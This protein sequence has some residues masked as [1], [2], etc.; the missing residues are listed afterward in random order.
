M[1]GTAGTNRRWCMHGETSEPVGPFLTAGTCGEY[2]A[3]RPSARRFRQSGWVKF[4]DHLRTWDAAGLAALL[5]ARPD[6]LPAAD[7]GFEALARRASTANSL[8]R[9][10][11][12]S[13]VAMF[14][15]AQ[16]LAVSHPA[17]A[18]EIDDLLGTND[19]DAVLDALGRLSAQGIVVV[20]D[21]VASPVGALD[22]LFH[23][24]LGLGPSF[25]ELADHL[26][27]AVFDDLAD[28]LGAAGATKRSATSRAIA[29]RLRSPE[30]LR[31]AFEGAP[32]EAGEL[33][34]VLVEQRSPAV[35]LPVG[36]R[37]Q[38]PPDDEPLA[39]MLNHGLLAPVSES[40]AELPR[41]IVIGYRSDGLTPQAMLRP[42]EPRPVAGL[43]VESVIAAAADRAG[44]TLEAAESLLRLVTDGEVAVRKTGGVGIREL[45]RLAKLL[46]LEDRQVGRLLELLAEAKLLQAQRGRLVSTPLADA[47][48]NLARGRRWLI[49]V[50]AWLA[51]PGFLSSA[52]SVGADDRPV[53]ALI[54]H[55]TV[56]AAFAGR[57][58][59][60]E[61]I[62]AI[63]A[64]EAFDPDQLCTAVVWRSPNLWGAGEPPPEDL[65]E[66][67]FAEAELLGLTAMNAPSPTLTA[68]ASDDTDRLEASAAELLGNDQQQFVL[69]SDLTAVALGPLDPGVAGRLNDLADRESDSSVPQYRFSESSLRRG[70][71]RGWSAET[72]TAFLSDHALSG[73]PQPLAY[74]LADVDRRY[75]SVKVVAASAVIVTEDEALAVEVASTTR[76]ARLGLRLIAPTV[77]VGPVDP[78]ELV[79]EL[80]AEGFFPIFD[81]DTI[82]FE[83]DIDRGIDDVGLP[84]DWTGPGLTEAALAGEVADAVE[85]LQATD[86]GISAEPDAKHRLHLLWNRTAVVTHLR[87]GRLTEARGVVVAV[88]ESLTL[89]NENGVEELPM[90]AVVTVEDPS[91]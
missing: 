66:W 71:D 10:L 89:L 65:V 44:R 15:V 62:S 38:R 6:L 29:R 56:A 78:H 57:Q 73:L 12:R 67:T 5:S 20:E 14:L 13:D 31:R 49:L 63:P 39:W 47:W 87:D 43:P 64:G 23:R 58:V 60:I 50:R 42:I 25:V 27:P 88:D 74:L 69:Q 34:G 37:Y 52:L 8:G 35:G 80:R 22:D 46:E 11:V 81:G 76:A 40:V 83:A 4:A 70:L 82:R 51:A 3:G 28:R 79:E 77:L 1:R 33:L 54:E 86:V 59:V 75:G 90:D 85:A 26:D 61:M 72:I 18:D 9:A 53:P 7:E 17:T 84:A 21:R 55:E 41:E 48:W 16:A 2:P 45:R 24:P 36:Y 91:R 30:G 19:V 32:P 68:L